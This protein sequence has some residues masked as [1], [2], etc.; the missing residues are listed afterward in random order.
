MQMPVSCTFPRSWVFKVLDQNTV[1][2]EIA[3]HKCK[4]SF[5]LPVGNAPDRLANAIC[6]KCSTPFV[7]TFLNSERA[8]DELTR[9]TSDKNSSSVRRI[10]FHGQGGSLFG[11]QI[12]NIFLTLMTLGIYYFWG[13]VRS[14]RYLLSQT[15]LEGDRFAYTGNGKELLVGFLR[16]VLLF[17]VPYA[18]LYFL[19][20]LL[21]MGKSVQILGKLLATGVIMLFIPVAIVNTRRYRLSRTSWRGISFSFRGPAGEF[22]KLF[23]KGMLVTVITIGAYYPIFAI[24]RQTFFVSHSCI[25]DQQFRFDG[26]IWGLSGSFLA[27]FLLTP[28]TLG[29]SWFWFFAKKQNYFWDHTSIK[30]ARFRST[31][32]GKGLLGLHLGNL[33]LLV[34]TLGLS[35]PWVVVRS[36]R[37]TLNNLT[38]EG[39]LNLEEIKQEAQDASAVGEGLAAILDTGFDFG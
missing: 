35:W 2:A 4:M 19:P 39:P 33:L 24:R 18:M 10:S 29:L 8:S 1:P 23:L 25:G 17:G 22:L 9:H 34:L 5:R 32:T 7:F 12:V 28:F 27:A 3:C 30:A 16:A 36:I 11:I 21:D 26:Q 14:R 37:Y 6:E 20:E 15:E 13:K 31:V 38:L